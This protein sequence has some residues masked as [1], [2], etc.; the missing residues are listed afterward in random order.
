MNI[1]EKR[2]PEHLAIDRPSAW[3][4]RFAP[5][6]P[7]GEVLDLACGAGRHSRLLAGI[8]HAVLA[9]DRSAE[10]LL[11]AAGQGITTLQVD[12]ESDD[13]E[14]NWP[15]A[16]NRFAGAVVTNYLFR[17]LFD[18]LIGSLMPNGVLLYETF[19]RGNEQFGKPSNP[20]FLLAH[21]ELL[22]LANKHNLQVV[23]YEDGYVDQ[24]KPAMVQRICLIKPGKPLRAEN[25]RLM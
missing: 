10:S 5:L 6:I 16:Q 13:A 3:I 20:D 25:L 18:A 19:A 21:G 22:Q 8:G 1:S 15:F 4:S 24:P 12:L 11:L 2:T 7:D 23:A 9:V 14:S 17:P